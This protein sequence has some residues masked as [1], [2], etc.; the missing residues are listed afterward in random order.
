MSCGCGKK[1]DSS[2]EHR[3]R[4]VMC[5]TCPH[6]SRSQGGIAV[7]CTISG[8]LVADHIK[9]KKPACPKKRHGATIEWL[10]I[11]W[12][13]VPMPIRVWMMDRLTGPLPG[14]GCIKVLK[15]FTERERQIWNGLFASML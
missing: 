1:P 13:G 11:V 14:C 10:R 12:Y 8:L 6:A 9:A 2:L 5:Q 3:A 4:A 15:D 7:L